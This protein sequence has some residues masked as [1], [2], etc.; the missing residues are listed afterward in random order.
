MYPGNHAFA[1]IT[2]Y[3]NYIVVIM[4]DM[5]DY[6]TLED[7]LKAGEIEKSFV[8]LEGAMKCIGQVHTSTCLAGMESEDKKTMLTTFL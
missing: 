1:L 3:L 6:C 8:N 7:K 4:E 5:T 2:V